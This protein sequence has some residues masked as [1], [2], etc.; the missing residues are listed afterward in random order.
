MI[1][2]ELADYHN[3]AELEAQNKTNGSM[4]S[5]LVMQYNHQDEDV[6][7]F[8]EPLSLTQKNGRSLRDTSGLRYRS[9]HKR[10]LNTS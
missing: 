8:N 1:A 4:N 10:K 5:S 3:Q 6:N 2:E 7:F 9:N